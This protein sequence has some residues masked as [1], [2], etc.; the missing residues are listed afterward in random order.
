VKYPRQLEIQLN[1]T[2]DA[3]PEEQQEWLEKELLPLGEKQIPF[4]AFMSVLQVATVG[5]MFLAFWVI[6]KNI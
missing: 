5:F 1:K 3:T 6:E 4:I 2:R